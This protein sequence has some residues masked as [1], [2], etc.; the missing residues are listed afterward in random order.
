MLKAFTPVSTMLC[1]FGFGLEKPSA[2]LI[3]AVACICAGVVAASYGEVNFSTFGLLAMLVSI[4]AEGL[5]TCMMQQLLT[6]K[7][8]HPLEAWMYL[9]PATTLWLLL[10]IGVFEA[11]AMR[12]QHAL[13]AVAAAHGWHFG[14]AALAGAAV[15]ALAMV[16]IQLG[17]ALTLKVLGICKDIG[18]VGLGVALLGEHVGSL[19]VLGYC[20]SLVGFGYYNW[21]KLAA[22]GLPEPSTAAGDASSGCSS[23]AKLA[24]PLLSAYHKLGCDGD[25]WRN[26]SSSSSSLIGTAPACGRGHTGSQ[27]VLIHVLV[28][29]GG[30]KNL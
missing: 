29:S 21:V 10:I 25:S 20:I 11:Q 12:D 4:A 23:P 13:T 30:V 28:P 5:R 7:A 3:A 26:S 8:F 17:S 15:N 16:V 18:L 14:F 1:G 24:V 9:G 27:S 19:Q 22:M 6:T 2:R